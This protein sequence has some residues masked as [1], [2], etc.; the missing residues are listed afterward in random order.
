MSANNTKSESEIRGFIEDWKK[1]LRSKDT[2]AIM[3]FY[4]PDILLFDLAPPLEYRGEDAYRKNWEEWFSSFKGPIGY[5]IRDLR[6]TAGDV[7]AFSH[8]LNRISGARTDGE[9]TEVWVRATVG[10]RKIDDKW[11]IA[12]EHFSVPFEMKEPYKALL[13][14]KP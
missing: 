8:S 2:D 1:A 3:S 9:Q 13:D 11:M 12:H 6:I 14:L 10:F 7:A 4:V 5:D